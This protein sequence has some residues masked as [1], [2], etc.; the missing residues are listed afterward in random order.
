[1]IIHSSWQIQDISK[2]EAC[3]GFDKINNN[4]EDHF[5]GMFH[6]RSKYVRTLTLRDNEWID[7]QQNT[8]DVY[9]TNIYTG[10]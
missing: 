8:D 1:M 2:G 4:A 10:Q 5:W 6:A 7:R 3:L 9:P